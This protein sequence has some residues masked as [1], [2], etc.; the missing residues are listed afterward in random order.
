M[1]SDIQSLYPGRGLSDGILD[2]FILL[3]SK[4][5]KTY[6]FKCISFIQLTAAKNKGDIFVIFNIPRNNGVKER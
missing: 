3:V 6:V 4:K 5:L 2:F 1:K